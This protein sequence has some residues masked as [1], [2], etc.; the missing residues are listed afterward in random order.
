MDFKIKI[1]SKL[2]DELG[3]VL[4]HDEGEQIMDDHDDLDNEADELDEV[5]VS[6]ALSEHLGTEDLDEPIKDKENMKVS[7]AF[8]LRSFMILFL[9][10]AF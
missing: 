1:N 8:I 2:F 10:F 9:L 5:D 6:E 3:I 7:F 4:S